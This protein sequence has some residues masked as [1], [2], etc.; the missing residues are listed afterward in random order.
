MSLI[1]EI[2]RLIVAAL[3]PLVASAGGGEKEEKKEKGEGKQEKEKEKKKRIVAD[4]VDDCRGQG[5]LY[6]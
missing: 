6:H 5:K 4:Q 3:L 2:S 1:A